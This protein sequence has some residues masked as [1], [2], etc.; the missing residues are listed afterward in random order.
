MTT[1]AQTALEEARRRSPGIGD[2]P[3]L[4]AP[5]AAGKSVS[6]D[7]ARTWWSKAERLAKLKHQPWRGWHSLR[8]KFASDL[9]DKPLKIVCTLG[10][11]KS[12]QTVLQCYQHPNQEEMRSALAERHGA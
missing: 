9:M 1:V 8:R 7:L 6:R 12:S 3:I 2:A 10:G 5:R 11:W 4:P